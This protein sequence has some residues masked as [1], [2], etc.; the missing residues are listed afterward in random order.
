VP[1]AAAFPPFPGVVKAGARGEPVRQVQQRLRDRGWRIR[2][3][4]VFDAPTDL[5]VRKFQTDKRLA[6]DGKVGPKTWTA[7]WQ[8]AIT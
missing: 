5:V 6:S 3:T 4:A 2:V 8:S 7:L 1:V